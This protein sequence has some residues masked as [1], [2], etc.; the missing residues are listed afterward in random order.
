MTRTCNITSLCCGKY[1]SQRPSWAWAIIPRPWPVG[2]LSGS[3]R[4]LTSGPPAR[5]RR[6]QASIGAGHEHRNSSLPPQHPRILDAMHPHD[7]ALVAR[8]AC[9]Q[10]QPHTAHDPA[11]RGRRAGFDCDAAQPG[12]GLGYENPDIFEDPE[13]VA[14]VLKLLDGAQ[15]RS[16]ISISWPSRWSTTSPTTACSGCNAASSTCAP[17]CRPRPKKRDS[18]TALGGD[19]RDVEARSGTAD[20]DDCSARCRPSRSGGR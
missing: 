2:S 15:S 16:R 20:H 7:H 18:V 4:G 8:G 3:C 1:R 5:D 11:R 10:R 17:S 13:F 6:H 12:P 19:L 14:T 9:G